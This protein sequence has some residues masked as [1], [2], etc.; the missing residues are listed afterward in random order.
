MF[1]LY[2]LGFRL[3]RYV[4]QSACDAACDASACPSGVSRHACL[5]GFASKPTFLLPIHSRMSR[6][7]LESS[8]ARIDGHARFAYECMHWLRLL[9][10]DN[11]ARCNRPDGLIRTM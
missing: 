6:A 2:E 5:F 4:Q 8:K 7:A 11:F 10:V 9:Q 1:D 3:R